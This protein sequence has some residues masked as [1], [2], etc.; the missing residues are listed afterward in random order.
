MK[1]F[2][3]TLDSIMLD[4]AD[5]ATIYP[6]FLLGKNNTIGFV[7]SEIKLFCDIFEDGK[8]IVNE[9]VAKKPKGIIPLF[10]VA[11][12]F[13]EIIKIPRF[14]EHDIA[15][16]KIPYQEIDCTGMMIKFTKNIFHDGFNMFLQSNGKKIETWSW[17]YVFVKRKNGSIADAIVRRID[18]PLALRARYLASKNEKENDEK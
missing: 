18:R 10:E 6:A 8:G 9:L 5:F 16:R 14:G 2:T 17:S 3:G 13:N 12:T 1:I 7:L 15:I 4:R 11:I